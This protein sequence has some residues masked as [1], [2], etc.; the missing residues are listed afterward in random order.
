MP[1]ASG[2]MRA[3]FTFKLSKPNTGFPPT[4]VK[5][6]KSKRLSPGTAFDQCLS[7]RYSIAAA[8][9]QVLDL[10][11][12][13]NVVGET[14]T[15]TKAVGI[16]LLAT[17]S[18]ARIEE[19]GTNGLRWFATSDGDIGAVV[20]KDGGFFAWGEPT[21]TTIDATHKRLKITNTGGT[22]LTVDVV[23]FVKD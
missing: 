17:G 11:S 1:L 21:G 10:S 23:I 6:T 15:G 16:L 20:V 9:E 22:T 3:N 4:V 7:A 8:G 2:E 14:V 18:T 12:F 19:D 13:T 5:S